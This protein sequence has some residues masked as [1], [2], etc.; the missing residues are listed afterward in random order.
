MR[1]LVLAGSDRASHSGVS[2]WNREE[3]PLPT[4][5]CETINSY[6][7]NIHQADFVSIDVSSAGLATIAYYGNI[8]TSSG[9]LKVAYQRLLT[10]LPLVVR[11]P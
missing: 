3:P 10:F 2:Q 7:F 8:S 4:W 5:K 9:D 1:L 11:H 6:A